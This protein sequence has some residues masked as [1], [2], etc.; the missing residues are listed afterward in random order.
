MEPSTRK[1]SE[2]EE[3][4]VEEEDSEEECDEGE[5][6]IPSNPSQRTLS[7]TDYKKAF[8]DGVPLCIVATK[9]PKKIIAPADLEVGTRKTRQK[10]R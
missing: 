10:C 9:I 8:G 7:E 1:T 3:D 2:S 6:A 5:V 4:Y